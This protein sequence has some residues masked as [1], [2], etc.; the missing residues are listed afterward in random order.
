MWIS[1][2]EEVNLLEYVADPFVG[3]ENVVWSARQVSE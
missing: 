1:D 2:G 3:A